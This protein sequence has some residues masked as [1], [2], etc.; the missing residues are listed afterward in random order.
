[1]YWDALG[2]SWHLGI[3][4]TISNSFWI[5]LRPQTKFAKVMFLQVFVYPQGGMRGEGEACLVKG[6]MDGERV[7]CV[8]KG[9]M[10]GKGGACM[11][12]GAS[13]AKGDICGKGGMHGKGGHLWQRG[14]CMVKGDMHGRG[15]VWRS[16]CVWQRHVWQGM[17]M[18]RGA[19]MH[20]RQLLNQVVHILLECILFEICFQTF[21]NTCVPFPNMCEQ[22]NE[23]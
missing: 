21:L 10:C 4:G 13:M 11:V 16:V 22:V 5:L 6:G 20:E 14:S 2:R 9:D 18:A 23:M 19:C 7:A 15:H 8:A 12:K 17:C 1:M 3:F